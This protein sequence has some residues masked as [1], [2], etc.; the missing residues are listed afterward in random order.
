M[1]DLTKEDPEILYQIIH[2]IYTDKYI[3]CSR[4]R[5]DDWMYQYEVT[6][7][8]DQY[9]LPQLKREA[10]ARFDAHV[11]ELGQVADRAVKERV[12]LRVDDQRVLE[13][14][15]AGERVQRHLGLAALDLERVQ[16]EGLHVRSSWDKAR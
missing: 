5:K 8:A 15:T 6:K 2:Y 14:Q 11:D 9:E 16:D 12:V 13:L 4:S 10:L 1:L 3:H 7:M